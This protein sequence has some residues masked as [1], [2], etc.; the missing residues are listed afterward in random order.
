MVYF[1]LI[2]INIIQYTD[3]LKH[4]SDNIII[5]TY[6]YMMYISYKLYSWLYTVLKSNYITI[7]LQYK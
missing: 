1:F 7:L 6:T 2:L 5:Q 4:C 3:E